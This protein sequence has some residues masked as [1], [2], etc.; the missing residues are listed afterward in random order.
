MGQR[1]DLGEI[2]DL[3]ARRLP[4]SYEPLLLTFY[5]RDARQSAE[6]VI[7][8]DDYGTQLHVRID[9]TVHSVDSE[10]KRLTR[11]MNSSVGQLAQFI[12][13]VAGTDRENDDREREMWSRLAAIDPAAF[14][15]E[16][17]CW[18]VILEQVRGEA[19]W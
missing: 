6:D 11:F 7:I 17:N 4:S 5:G 14:A 2:R 8:G 18:A 10:G 16:E 13:V 1:N 15:N 19:G 3:L 12:E 9:G